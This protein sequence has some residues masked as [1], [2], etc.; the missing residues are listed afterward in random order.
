MTLGS[1]V[2]EKRL[3]FLETVTF[4][5][6]EFFVAQLI[7]VSIG[8]EVPPGF[9]GAL[10]L[11]GVEQLTFSFAAAQVTLDFVVADDVTLGVFTAHVILGSVKMVKLGFVVAH[12]TLCLV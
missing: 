10:T 4:G 12:V 1:I 7:L 11:V 3:G 5:G 6:V 8:A 2:A 9:V